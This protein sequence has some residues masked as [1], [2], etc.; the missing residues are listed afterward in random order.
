LNKIVCGLFVFLHIQCFA[1]VTNSDFQEFLTEYYAAPNTEGFNWSE[2]GFAIEKD[3]DELAL[4]CIDV[5]PLGKLEY[6]R[7]HVHVNLPPPYVY[8][9]Y[10]R[11]VIK[12]KISVLKALLA[13]YPEIIP[14]GSE[15]F[16]AYGSFANVRLNERQ[17]LNIA[18]EDRYNSFEWI[19][20]LLD[21]GADLNVIEGFNNGKGEYHSRSPLQA[22]IIFDKLDVVEFLLENG[23]NPNPGLYTAIQSR[24]LEALILLLNFGADPYYN[25]GWGLK[26]ALRLG[27]SE[28]I[29]A[30]VNVYFR[31]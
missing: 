17:I 24:N 8:H 22:A 15:Y 14:N 13:K 12:D 16:L 20:L 3:Y 11:C 5:L 18:I 6:M 27:Y 10:C 9:L 1:V 25:N 26:E 31:E 19:K 28:I 23:V 30:L 4:F 2:I 7:G 21:A 29:D